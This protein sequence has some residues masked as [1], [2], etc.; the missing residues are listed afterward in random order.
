[1]DFYAVNILLFNDRFLAI[2]IEWS[3]FEHLSHTTTQ[4]FKEIAKNEGII[5]WDKNLS[6]YLHQ[7]VNICPQYS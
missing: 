7:K 2:S 4:L 6:L 5:W 3:V 1:M